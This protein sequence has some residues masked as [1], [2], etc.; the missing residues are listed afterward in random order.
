MV[1]WPAFDAKILNGSELGTQLRNGLMQ[2]LGQ[3]R[4][5][6]AQIGHPKL[7]DFK[8]KTALRPNR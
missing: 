8:A 4:L 5:A 7:F 6:V 1:H 3:L 2:P